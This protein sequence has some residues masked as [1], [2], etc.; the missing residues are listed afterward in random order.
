MATEK[1]WFKWTVEIQVHRTW[2]EDGFELTNES[3]KEMIENRLSHATGAETKARVL[4]GPEPDE[5]AKVQGYK[6]AADRK[7]KES[8]DWSTEEKKSRSGN[9]RG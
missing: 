4:S 2:V 5:I 9:K 3:A 1:Q 7:R 8:G 6:D